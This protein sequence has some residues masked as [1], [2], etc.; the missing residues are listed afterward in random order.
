[1]ISYDWYMISIFHLYFW[2]MFVFRMP[3]CGGGGVLWRA[4]AAAA[5]S[6]LWRAAVRGVRRPA[7]CA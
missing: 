3:V 5:L 7:C 6:S 1:M 4:V 2:Y